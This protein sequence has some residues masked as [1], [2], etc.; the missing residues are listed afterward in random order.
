MMG[1]LLQQDIYYKVGVVVDLACDNSVAALHV[2]SLKKQFN[3]QKFWLLLENGRMIEDAK[4]ELNSSYQVVYSLDNNIYPA[5]EDFDTGIDTN[6]SYSL[7]KLGTAVLPELRILADCEVTWVQINSR[8]DQNNF[9][10]S[11]DVL[12]LDIYKTSMMQPLNVS[13]TGVAFLSDDKEDDEIPRVL[14]AKRA[15]ITK[16]RGDFHGAHFKTATV[17]LYPEDFTTWDDLRL[18]HI[19]KWSKIHWPIYGY[20]AEQ[21]NYSFEVTYQED[22]YGWLING[23]FDGMMGYMQREE[24][25][26]PS[27]GIFI[28]KD[29]FAVTSYA[30]D[31]FSLRATTIFRQPSLSTVSNIFTL[32]FDSGV[33]MS[34]G[35]LCLAA[36]FILGLQIIWTV[37]Q[38]VEKDM[39]NAEWSD[40]V[41]LV[42][43][44]ICQQ[45]YHMTPTSLGGRV[46]V[47]FLM[48]ASLF[49]FTSYSANIVALLQTTSSAFKSIKDLTHSPMIIGV[50]NQTYNRVYMKETTDPE[51][52]EFYLRKVA[53]LGEKIYRHATIGMADI[54]QTMH[55][56]QVDTT[57][58]YKIMSE[59][60]EEH[61]KCGLQ[62]V[63]LFPAPVFTISTTRGSSL[64]EYFGQR[65]RWYREV[66]LL[67]R[68][69]KIWMPQKTKCV[70]NSGGFVSVSLT[71]FYPAVLV[72]EYGTALAVAILLLEVLYYYR[73]LITTKCSGTQNH[74]K[75]S[76]QTKQHLSK[77]EKVITP[78]STVVK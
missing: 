40:V 57:A 29:R 66:G 62:E 39:V 44:A 74:E 36:V 52:R 10:G 68:L 49:L 60:Y 32:P 3:L 27:T 7:S 73:Y 23:S 71:E 77:E 24:V 34:C 13:I 65:V 16:R 51:L 20:L 43:G 47:F 35:V 75:E 26:F 45:G 38:R 55:A 6:F 11:P 67:D 28:R 59:T 70:S 41:T 8:I 58:A 56:F 17:L 54:K 69:F 46:T 18:R 72:L 30:A 48:L 12:L 14:F 19:D 4:Q 53:P 2:A 22:N 37:R 33:W 21:M 15:E 76:H 31:T 64:K 42:L 5:A 63:D 25:E 78:L 1:S 9:A 50:E 61:E